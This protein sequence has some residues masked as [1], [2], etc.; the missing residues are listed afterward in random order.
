M[1]KSLEAYETVSGLFRS[2]DVSRPLSIPTRRLVPRPSKALPVEMVTAA[3]QTNH[4][5]E[6][7][8]VQVDDGTQTE[9]GLGELE[10]AMKKMRERKGEGSAK[11]SEDTEMKDR[12]YN[13]DSYR[14]M[15]EDLSG[16]E[17]EDVALVSAPP[18]TNKKQAALHSAAKPAGKRSRPAKTPPRS[19]SPDNNGLLVKAM[20][21][22]GVPRQRP[23]GETIPDVG[24]KRIIGASWLLGGMRRLG[25]ATSSAVVFFYRKLALGS[26]LK[27]RGRWLPIEVYDFDRGR[28]RVEVSDW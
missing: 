8:V 20:V 10:K 6:P 26:H 2:R 11:D 18:A 15:Y 5:Q 19:I 3:T 28:R 16:Y 21:I 17:D 9:V 27:V 13:S 12:S 1:S 24:V 23:M 25:K 4:F 14:E 7:T 22:H